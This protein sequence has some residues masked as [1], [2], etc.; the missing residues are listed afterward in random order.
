M[1]K[2]IYDNKSLIYGKIKEGNV[3]FLAWKKKDEENKEMK[4][5]ERESDML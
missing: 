4:E 1:V 2:Y 3:L 5:W